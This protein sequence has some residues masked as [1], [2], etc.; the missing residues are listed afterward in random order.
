MTKRTLLFLMAVLTA[1]SSLQAQVINEQQALQQARRFF[2]QMDGSSQA[3]GRRGVT[4]PTLVESLDMTSLADDAAPAFYVFNRG[5]DGGF[6]IVSGDS[7]TKHAI[8]GYSSSGTFHAEAMPSNVKGWLEGYAGEI[9]V[10]RKSNASINEGSGME[11]A[12]GNIVVAPL[13]TTQWDQG[14]PFNDKCPMRKG[15]RT[16]VGCAAVAAAQVM[17]YFRWPQQGQGRLEYD[18]ATSSIERDFS[19]SRYD[20]DNLDVAQFLFDVAAGGLTDFNTPESSAYESD[21]ARGMIQYFDYDKSMQFHYRNRDGNDSYSF[22]PNWDEEAWDNLL[23]SELDARRP[24]LYGGTTYNRAGHEFICDGYDDAG[25]FHFN[26]GWGG[27]CDG[28]FLTTSLCPTDMEWNNSYHWAQTAIIGIQ[29]NKGGNWVYSCSGNYQ[30]VYGLA[31]GVNVLYCLENESTHDK[32]YGQPKY[33]ALSANEYGTKYYDIPKEFPQK[34]QIPAGTY[35]KYL[36]LNAPGTDVY[37][38]VEYGYASDKAEEAETFTWVDIAADGTWTESS[39]RT[40][41]TENDNR[42]KQ[43]YFILNDNEVRLKSITWD[44]DRLPSVLDSVVTYR[45]KEYVVTEVDCNFYNMA[46]K[47]PTTIKKMTAVWNVYG[48]VSFPPYLEELVLRYPGSAPLDF[49]PTLKVLDIGQHLDY[50]A[51]TEL[52]LPPSLEA[53]IGLYASEITELTIP[54]SVRYLLTDG[55]EGNRTGAF[56]ANKLKTLIFED[57]CTAKIPN[58]LS[59]GNFSKVILGEGIEEIEGFDLCNNLIGVKL[60][61]SVKRISGGFFACKNLEEVVVPEGSQLEELSNGAFSST[62]NLWHFD[63]PATLKVLDDAFEQSGITAADLSQTQLEDINAFKS[64]TAMKSVVLPSTLKTITMLGTG[65]AES[66]TVPQG[67]ETIGCLYGSSLRSLTL[68]A[69]LKSVTYSEHYSGAKVYCNAT[70]PPEG[71]GLTCTGTGGR[72]YR[73]IYLY[74]PAGTSAAYRDYVYIDPSAGYTYR[75]YSTLIEM[76]DAEAP[77]NVIA[78]SDGGTVMGSSE[79]AGA[80][81]IPATVATSDGTEVAVTAI[82]QYAFYGNASLTSV[83]IPATVG[84]G[85]TYTRATTA[86]IGQYAFA[87]CMNMDT[88]RVHWMEPLE[89]DATVFEGLD[90]SALTLI[91]PDNTTALYASADVW[92]KFGT[93]VEETVAGIDSP[94]DDA[95]TLDAAKAPLYDLFGRPVDAN[96]PGIYI[97]AGR[98]V[99]VR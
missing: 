31:E 7:R 97:Q 77:V 99:L 4:T 83:D 14:E 18:W 67:V 29:P 54:A 11:E 12:V 79:T 53:L 75:Y 69:S 94:K 19:A 40:F 48:T 27:Y 91:V 50:Y 41:T 88:V 96:Q 93:I 32:Y 36:V 1:L 95:A 80:V 33:Y 45:G 44:N 13:I 59:Y 68:P 70:T 15:E 90:L 92:K 34:E 64:C 10:I 84:P 38:T 98:K 17:N 57:G 43:N 23:R 46:P 71:S 82:G 26:W 60:P 85:T 74:I 89:I 22:L 73:N 2:L 66:L 76:V 6:V 81:E 63:F 65:K 21:L 87:Y 30:F 62:S 49:P 78:D 37:Q 58:D 35:R 42:F 47:F 3:A 20:Y 5:D 8:L 24:V 52:T 9:E 61:K 16:A 72:I 28:W 39:S 55:K 51:G 25:Y 86:G 56:K